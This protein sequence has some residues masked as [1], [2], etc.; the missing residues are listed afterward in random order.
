MSTKEGIS[1]V[2]AQMGRWSANC[3][4]DMSVRQ[5]ATHSWKCLV[6]SPQLREASH[7]ENFQESEWVV[8]Q[9]KRT[10]NLEPGP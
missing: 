7:G 5:Q 6:G 8:G 4:F 3:A 2:Q 10:A 1:I 9:L